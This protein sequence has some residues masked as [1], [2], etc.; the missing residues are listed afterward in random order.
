LI[1]RVC[2]ANRRQNFQITHAKSL[3]AA[4]RFR[5]YLR[6]TL[7]NDKERKSA[8]I[9][10]RK[11]EDGV[12][13]RSFDSRELKPSS[14]L[15]TGNSRSCLFSQSILGVTFSVG[16]VSAGNDQSSDSK[17]AS[18]YAEPL[19]LLSMYVSSWNISGRGHEHGEDIL[20]GE[21]KGA[22][23]E[24]VELLEHDLN[25]PEAQQRE[26]YPEHVALC[27][28]DDPQVM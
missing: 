19:P 7:I 15:L 9:S 5:I 17:F 12:F 18:N 26:V 24:W 22:L 4:E 20:D 14:Q 2:P 27:D 25:D 10:D 1:W 6:K 3:N 13:L 28:G 11:T 23:A 8:Q 16:A 21:V